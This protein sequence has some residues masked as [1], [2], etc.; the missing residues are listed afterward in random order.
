MISIVNYEF[1]DTESVLLARFDGSDEPY[2]PKP[3]HYVPSSVSCCLV[4]LSWDYLGAYYYSLVVPVK[5]V[6]LVKASV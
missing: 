2:H 5:E 4:I 6:L 1:G 3:G